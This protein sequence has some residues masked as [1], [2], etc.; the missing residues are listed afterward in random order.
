LKACIFLFFCCVLQVSAENNALFSDEEYNLLRS[1]IL[2]N[3]TNKP[4][5]AANKADEFLALYQNKFTPSQ[6]LRMH[7]TKAYFQIHSE[8]FEAAYTTLRQCKELA[9]GVNDP[10]L[11]Y[12]YY[13]YLGGMLNTLESFELSLE[14][15][16]QAVDLANKANDK[17]MTAQAYNNVGHVLI[18]LRK[19]D[20]A[21]IYLDKFY[22]YGQSENNLS[23]ISTALNNF[24]EIA[25]EQGD[26]EQ[27]ETYFLQSLDIREKND[28]VIASS[29]S[30]YNLG[31]I[32]LATNNYPKAI[33]HLKEAIE[34]RQTTQLLLESLKPKITLA[35]VYIS[36]QKYEKA[37]PLIG[38]TIDVATS[39]NSYKIASDA[40]QLLR[41]YHLK[42][43]NYQLA[44]E[45]T[46]GFVKNKL[47]LL[48]R[49]SSVSL[50]HYLAKVELNIKEMDNI[51]LRKKNELVSQQS[52]AKETQLLITAIMGGVIIVVILLFMRK[53]S[54][55]NHALKLTVDEL[56]KT[57]KDLI[58]ADKMS[59]M[60]TLVSGIAHQLNTP[61]G[62][63]ITAN[64]VMREK[65]LSLEHQF[66][67]KKLNLASFKEY[68]DDA[69]S[70]LELT[71]KNSEKTAELVQRFKMISAELEG[72]KISS[73]ELKLFILEKFK[74]IA[75]QYQEILSVE[76][77]GAEVEVLNYPDVLFKVL[78]QLVKNT[79]EHKPQDR[80]DLTAKIDINLQAEKVEIIYTDNGNGISEQIREKIFNPFF[81]TKG[82]QKSLGLGLNIA[83]NSV[84]HLMQGK[85][86][87]RASSSGAKFV[88]EIPVR[89]A[90][91]TADVI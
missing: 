2:D 76:V 54:H 84:M 15:Y 77:N 60:T 88:I 68:I 9:D 79:A 80:T 25:L 18:Q 8:Q 83:Y 75:S 17:S 42:Q 39:R 34:I 51:E 53:L 87:C 40:Y 27:A 59:A 69:K 14:A 12:Y 3:Y 50:M 20:E 28:F 48:E 29:W 62:V 22:Q 16:F 81:T 11:T 49:K 45:A 41:Q 47:A 78:E 6:Y 38:S 63:V 24:G 46:D 19:F 70:V 43:Q 23:Y 7:Y 85:L 82:M 90:Q 73:F 71:E 32:Y 10:A 86:S 64:S 56:R 58:E 4:A 66:N 61:L 31:K 72:S 13:S 55:S 67:D 30:H 26:I 74:L 37:L 44:M 89:L 91:T 52:K 33:D 36:Q 35:E 57:Q 5:E 1:N 21:K 65:L